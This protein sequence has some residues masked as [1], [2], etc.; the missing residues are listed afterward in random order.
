[1]SPDV[2]AREEVSDALAGVVATMAAGGKRAKEIAEL[3]GHAP[4]Y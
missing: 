3:T 1:M 4:I 2:E